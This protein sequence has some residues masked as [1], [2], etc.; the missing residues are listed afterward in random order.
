MQTFLLIALIIGLIFGILQIILFFKL[1][2]MTNNVAIMLKIMEL[3]LTEEQVN[4]VKE[5]KP[6]DI[7]FIISLCLVLFVPVFVY[8]LVR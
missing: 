2:N 4:K 3:N 1:W 7:V 8:F 6:F 5:A